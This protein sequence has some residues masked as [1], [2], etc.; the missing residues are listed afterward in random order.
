MALSDS[1]AARLTAC[2]KAGGV[3]VFP[4]DTVY[5]LGC[6]PDSEDAVRRLYELKGRPADRPAAVMFFDRTRALEALPELRAAERAA[7]QAL[8]PDR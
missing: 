1:D 8:L 5:G 6:D 3:V 7:V 2:L 4:T